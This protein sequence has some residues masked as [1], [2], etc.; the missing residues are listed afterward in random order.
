MTARASALR[1]PR[2]G[3]VAASTPQIL[4]A[5]ASAETDSINPGEKNKK[6]KKEKVLRQRS[7]SQ[8]NRSTP[9]LRAD[10]KGRPTAKDLARIKSTKKAPFSPAISFLPQLVVSDN[11]S[12]IAAHGETAST[13]TPAPVA[14][15]LVIAEPEL[16][17]P[18]STTVDETSTDVVPLSEGCAPTQ[19][20]PPTYHENPELIPNSLSAKPTFLRAL[21]LQ[22]TALLSVAA[23]VWNWT[24]Q[25][26]KTHQVKKRLRV[27]ET[28]SLGEKRFVAVIQVDGEQFL[29]GGSS[30]SVSTLAHL[31]PRREFSDV[32]RNR[33]DQDLSQA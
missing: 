9:R 28:V 4:S 16:L 25:K 24:Q 29:V 12:T 26:L 11:V 2:T 27:C 7:G 18:A 20:D 6:V 14:P 13:A 31:E 10:K 30:S 5:L 1:V 22:F 17:E 15:V 21:A 3:A 33:C 19:G 8:K 23:R 32:L